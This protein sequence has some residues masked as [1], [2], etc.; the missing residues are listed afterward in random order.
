MI[1]ERLFGTPLRGKVRTKLEDRQ[2]VAGDIKPGN[3][4]QGV[5]EEGGKVLADLH[6]RTPFVRMWAGVKHYSDKDAFYDEEG[7][8]LTVEEYNNFINGSYYMRSGKRES[9]Q[10]CYHMYILN[11]NTTRLPL[12]CPKIVIDYY[13]KLVVTLPKI[14]HRLSFQNNG[15]YYNKERTCILHAAGSSKTVLPT[16]LTWMEYIRGKNVSTSS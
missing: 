15:I 1:N 9:D 8:D 2:R 5:F 10:S 4:I 11:Q 13:S 16:L 12:E 3:S 6:S 14:S 7:P